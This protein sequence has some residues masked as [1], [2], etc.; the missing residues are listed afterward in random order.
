MCLSKEWLLQERMLKVESELEVTTDDITKGIYVLKDGTIWSGYL[1]DDCIRDTE[2]R[3]IEAF[4]H[5]NRYDAGFWEEVFSHLQVVM[6]I[7]EA[8]QAIYKNLSYAQKVVLE[9]SNYELVQTD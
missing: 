2:H 4:T 8:E 1:W 5:T 9:K 3:E 7:P 6:L